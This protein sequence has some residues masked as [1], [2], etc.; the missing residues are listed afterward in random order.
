[1]VLL[2]L[3]QERVGEVGRRGSE[4]RAPRQVTQA[5]VSLSLTGVVV[6]VGDQ[7]ETQRV[8]AV[9]ALDDAQVADRLCQ[10]LPETQTAVVHRQ[11]M[12]VKIP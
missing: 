3:E 4:G 10:T 2:V 8:C 11:G 7:A 9:Q 1:M 12:S 5:G 6:E